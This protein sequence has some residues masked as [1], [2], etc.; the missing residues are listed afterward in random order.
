[1]KSIIAIVALLA[2][3]AS[4]APVSDEESQVQ[5]RETRLRLVSTGEGL[6][7]WLDP[8]DLI[9]KGIK[10]IDK[11]DT[12]ELEQNA[13][14]TR[15][16]LAKF[17]LPSAPVQ[18]KAV[19]PLIKSIDKSRIKKRMETFTGFKNRYYRSK[20]GV[21]SAEWLKSTLESIIE[22]N[23]LEATVSEFKHS[24]NQP[25]LIVKIKGE[26]D[27]EDAPVVIVGSHQDSLGG[28]FGTGRY[29]GADD[30]GSGSMT[31]LEAF[32]VLAESGFKP[33]NNVEFHWY[34]AEEMGLLGSQAVA[35]AY[36]KE[37]KNVVAML[38]FDMTG[39]GKKH[40]IGIINDYV[41]KDLTVFL[42]SLA[43]EYASIPTA[44]SKCGYGCSDH[45]SWNNGGFRSAFPFEGEFKD[46]SPYIH[47][48]EDTVDHIDFD[49]LKEFV[50]LA[51]SY[52][53]ELS[54]H[55]F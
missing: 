47:G 3:I 45:A 2:S 34:S 9:D 1:M 22:S 32:T 36:Q 35:Q 16:R 12:Q 31:T 17:E 6:L 53:V 46:S 29:P 44:E 19:K 42:R 28:I 38:Q 51:I 41:D 43:K 18:Q 14:A 7:E 33:K 26:D 24:W 39:Y 11:T 40:V 30:D 37:E 4:S 15:Q 50:K 13:E 10:F 5:F 8:Q 27:S 23:S 20:Y 21:E 48:K 25:S 52:A 54:S 55:D 49:H